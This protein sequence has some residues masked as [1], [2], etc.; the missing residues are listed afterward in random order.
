V[1]AS[2]EQAA[3]FEIPVVKSREAV[4]AFPRILQARQQLAEQFGVLEWGLAQT[5][6]RDVF[7]ATVQDKSA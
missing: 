7:L 5:T 4:A 3:V 2:S 6:L 1:H